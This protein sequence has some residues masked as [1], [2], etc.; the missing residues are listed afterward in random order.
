MTDEMPRDRE[1]LD[2]EE[3]AELLMREA[4]IRNAL[5]SFADTGQALVAI[6]DKRLYRET[7]ATFEAYCKGVWGF[8]KSRATHYIVAAAVADT[9][10]NVT[11]AEPRNE[12]VCRELNRLT[13]KSE[14]K[15]A[16]CESVERY[17]PEPTSE[18]VRE[19]VLEAKMVADP[20]SPPSPPGDD[21]RW[22]RVERAADQLRGLPRVADIR[23]PT[24]AGDVA[25]M[26]DALAFF[27]AWL[28]SMNKV[29][30]EHKRRL[31]ASESRPHLR[32]VDAA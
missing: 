30:R 6:R 22:A 27:D 12:A 18:Q 26:D 23:L 2:A 19:V 15:G 32:A 3:R 5:R 13:G 7:H 8:S 14:Q 31:R 9:V 25:A 11:T 1:W 20:P 29:W 10:T 28:P 17:G 16:W 4:T 21:T 24:E